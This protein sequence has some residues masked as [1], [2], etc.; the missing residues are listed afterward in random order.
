MATT[1]NYTWP[2]SSDVTLTGSPNGAPIPSTSILVAGENPSGNQQ[3]LQTSAD[4]ALLVSPDPTSTGNVNLTEVS[5]AAITL[6]QKTSAASLPVVIASDQSTLPISAASLPL[7]TGAATSALQTTGN[8]SLAT[9]VTNTTGIATAANQTTGNTSLSSIL[10]NQTNG[11]QV[12]TI[13]GTVPLPTGSA[14][15]ANQTNGSQITQISQT[16]PGTTN[17]VV[18]NSS[19]LPTG[20]STS[21]LQTTGNT[22][23]ATIATNQTSGSQQT[24]IVNQ[25][26]QAITQTA[27]TVGTTAVRLTVSGSAPSA[28]I[29]TRIVTPNPTSAATFYLG[30]S[31]VTNTSGVPILAGQIITINHDACDY[32]IVSSVA[33]QTVYLSQEGT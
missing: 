22:S 18:V 21:A 23:L 12:T 30:G 17:G 13:T 10:A 4:G 29:G 19:A 8:T 6:G 11:T 32:F 1:Q 14:T 24:Q 27:L 3:V 20:A 28:T 16:T 5:G 31:S 9:I 2:A 15:A 7:P 25:A 26:A 33:A